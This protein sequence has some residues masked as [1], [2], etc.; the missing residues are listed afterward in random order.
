ST[1]LVFVIVLGIK[2][3]GAEQEQLGDLRRTLNEALEVKGGAGGAT[4]SGSGPPK[5]TMLVLPGSPDHPRTGTGEN[6]SAGGSTQHVPPPS[7]CHSAIGLPS[8]LG[9]QDGISTGQINFPGL[10]LS[11]SPSPN[12]PPKDGGGAATTSTS[13]TAEGPT[14]KDKEKKHS[15]NQVNCKSRP[16][17][18]AQQ[19]QV[20]HKRSDTSTSSVISSS[21]RHSHSQILAMNI[22]EESEERDCSH[23][24]A[25]DGGLLGSGT[26]V[27][28]GSSASSPSNAN[29]NFSSSANQNVAS[30]AI[31]LH[32]PTTHDSNSVEKSVSTGGDVTVEKNLSGNAQSLDL[33]EANQTKGLGLQ[34]SHST[35]SARQVCSPLAPI[36]SE[37]H[38][39]QV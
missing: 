26:N 11:S 35:R 5:S 34:Q 33:L 22:A 25:P 32:S 39:E 19:L 31:L 10:S 2:M 23:H 9:S 4:P 36:K 20:V 24:A 29:T 21:H 27:R 15:Q 38:A 3:A 37:R 8:V 28:T 18:I 7:P 1:P 17:S 13:S 6:I 14:S 16:G 30:A 12:P